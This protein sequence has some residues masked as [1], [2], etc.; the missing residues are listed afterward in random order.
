MPYTQ[1]FILLAVLTSLVVLGYHVGAR[2]ESCLGAAAKAERQYDIPT[3]LLAAIGEVES[4]RRDPLSGRVQ[5]WPWTIDSAGTGLYLPDADVA[6]RTLADLQDRGAALI[7][8]GCFQIDLSYHPNA[9]AT[10]S[11][12][13]DPDANADF[14]ARFL[15][16]LYRRLGSWPAAVAAYHSGAPIFGAPYRDRVLSLWHGVALPEARFGMTIWTPYSPTASGTAA[17]GA[18]LPHIIVPDL[19]ISGG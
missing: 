11:E 1:R 16:T 7:D 19:P 10:P 13:F 15:L 6:L 17:G 9:F 18:R 4:G 14:A 12:A 3:G 2:A 8:V 5:P